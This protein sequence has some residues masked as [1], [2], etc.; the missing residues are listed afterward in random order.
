MRII[1]DVRT[2]SER[3]PNVALTIGSFDGIHLGHRHIIDMLV[4]DARA[5]NGTAA[6]MTLRPH[7]RQ[8]FAPTSAPNILTSDAKKEQLLAEAGVDVLYV[9]P[10][11]AEVA[12]LDREDFVKEIVVGR[13]G[14]RKLV[15][16]HD[17]NFGKG[18][19][20][21]FEYLEAVAPGYGFVVEQAD[22]LILDGE[23][24]SSTLVRELILQGDL[25]RA[26]RFLGRKYSIVGEV[27]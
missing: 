17:F 27:I 24:V 8:F 1:D 16:G 12:S 5:M 3:F 9:L 13:C 7:P 11:N 6:L 20:G 10:F 22:A 25:E 26:E 19:K 4:A 15:V 21:N 14:A 2:C 23:R 18:A